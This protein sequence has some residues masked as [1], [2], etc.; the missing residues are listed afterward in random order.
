MSITYERVFLYILESRKHEFI[1][2]VPDLQFPDNGEYV[3]TNN[4]I[5]L[6][7]RIIQI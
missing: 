3:I 5:A 2:T 1:Q 7:I 6:I 4:Y